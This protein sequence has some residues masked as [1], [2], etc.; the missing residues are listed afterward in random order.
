MD[1][2]SFRIPQQHPPGENS[3]DTRAAAVQRWVGELPMGH[4]GET[5]KRLYEML[6]EVNHL[7]IPLGNRHELIEL[8]LPPLHTVLESLERHFTGM[9]FPLPAKSLRVAKF[10]NGLLREVVIAFQAILNSEENASW[11][12]RMTHTRIWLEA[13]HHLIY[14]LNRILCNYR[15]I[16]RSVPAGVWLAVHRLY[17]TAVE[18]DRHNDKVKP[19]LSEVP[20]T[21]EGE[22]KKALLLSMVEPQ[23]F[24]REQMAQLYANMPLWIERCELVESSLRDDEMIGYCIRLDTDAPHTKLTTECC[25]DC[26]G[27]SRAGVLLDLVGL[28]LLIGTLLEQLGDE[29]SLQPR[30]GSEISRETLETLATC[31]RSY[32]SE[33]HERTQQDAPAEVAIGMSSIFQLL[34]EST[35]SS[36]R[37]ISDQQM[38]D[39]LKQ[40]QSEGG[41]TLKEEG[42]EAN[43][44]SVMGERAE[45][46][47]WGTIFHA[48]EFTQKSWSF[49]PS[50]REYHYIHARQRDYTDS[51]YCLEFDK[52]HMEPFQVGELVGVRAGDEE[53]LHLCMV[54]WLNEEE[55]HVTAGVMRLA[56]SMEP[57]LVVLHQ[58][59]RQ[60]PL[61]C[62][63]GIGNDHRPHL[64]LPHLPG[65]RGKELFL[66]VDSKEVPLTLHD[67]VVVS[68]LF[69]AFHFN[70]VS[71]NGDEEMSLQQMNRQLHGLTHQEGDEQPDDD[72]SDLWGTL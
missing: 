20:T 50:E 19:P 27:D 68:P 12:Y 65:I 10:S 52:A 35:D 61:N 3:F 42:E 49:E 53:R 51:G 64:F 26:D 55:S 70:A 38:S 9:T 67:R 23:L 60:T 7:D 39:K 33:R 22:Y 54:R 32:D 1:S 46:D 57:A 29:P 47:V 6:R 37:G 2:L 59:A 41:F 31:W 56:D 11:F 48:T 71:I 58:S 30:G 25:D 4:V 14:Y 69:D 18:N 72:F 36:A 44:G 13:V 17:A 21:I 62:L 8:V 43:R 45:E 28:S 15:L 40:L 24:N 34:R 16:H 63:L 66:V 5:A